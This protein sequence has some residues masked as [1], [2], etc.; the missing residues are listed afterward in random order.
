MSN[1]VI[2][3]LSRQPIIQGAYIT[4]ASKPSFSTQIC[5]RT[6]H[7]REQR[8]T[9]SARE[10]TEIL[11]SVGWS[12]YEVGDAILF[13]NPEILNNE[14]LYLDEAWCAQYLAALGEVRWS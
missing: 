2:S 11:L 4:S 8:H 12:R 5:Q 9:F 6:K 3:I 7:I 13:T 14:P 10:K 1:N